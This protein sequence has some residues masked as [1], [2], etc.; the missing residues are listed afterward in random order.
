MR[1]YVFYNTGVMPAARARR[2]HSPRMMTVA[3]FSR[4]LAEA[5]WLTLEICGHRG[6][7][8]LESVNGRA[9][10]RSGCPEWLIHGGQIA[11]WRVQ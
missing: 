5:F 4:R 11:P 9:D 2:E 7:W 8:D 10:V 3:G 1:R 6:E